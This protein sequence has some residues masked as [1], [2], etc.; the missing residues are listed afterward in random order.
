MVFFPNT[1]ERKNLCVLVPYKVPIV[2]FCYH[3]AMICHQ[4]EYRYRWPNGPPGP[5]QPGT[6]QAQRTSV[7]GRVRPPGRGC[8]LGT[9][10][11]PSCRAGPARGTARPEG[12]LSPLGP[13]SAVAPI[14]A[15]MLHPC[16]HGRVPAP[17]R[18]PPCTHDGGG[19][20]PW[21]QGED[22]RGHSGGGHGE[23]GRRAALDGTDPGK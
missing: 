10:L 15:P 22:R 16:H 20:R 9:A 12:P 4:Q 2:W 11:M 3:S 13:T 8:G 6:T 17:S 5:T 21:P 1:T 14:R 19:G 23:G 18:P 7:S